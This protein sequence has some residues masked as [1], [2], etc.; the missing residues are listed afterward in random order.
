M[1]EEHEVWVVDEPYFEEHYARRAH[2]ERPERLQAAREGLRA[3]LGDWAPLTPEPLVRDAAARVHAIG[4]LDA[5]EEVLGG[6]G[7]LDPDTYICPTSG[8]A[9]WGAAGGAMAV[10]EKVA[11]GSDAIAL[12]RP[13]GHHARPHAAMG[14]CVLNNVAIAAVTA[15]AEGAERVAIFDWD[16]HHGN[17]TQEMFWTDERV[18]FISM[19]Q[20][21]FY[22]GTGAPEEIGEGAGRFGTI[23]VGLPA[24]SGPEAY[25]EAFRRVVR[26]ALRAAQPDV[27]LVSAGFDA[28][29]ADPLAMQELD[30]DTYGAFTTA[31]RRDH[32]SIGMLLEGGYDLDALSASLRCV[33]EALRGKETELAEGA[34]R[35]VEREAIER[36]LRAHR[37]SPFL[38]A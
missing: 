2:P 26:P 3:G 24:G 5:L 1:A 29:A 32:G 8:S 13:P 28:H 25:A 12:V 15:L 4:Y 6:W 20:F 9:I 21:P 36:T 37:G 7:Q 23:N 22:P 30:A 16:V 18:V 31:L 34:L 11:G 35:D 17:G 33:G 14:F 27:L 19:H 38:A 10:A